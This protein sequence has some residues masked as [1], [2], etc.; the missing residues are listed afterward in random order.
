VASDQ[1]W[2]C[3]AAKVVR[4]MRNAGGAILRLRVPTLQ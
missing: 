4:D 1:G 3:G 2:T